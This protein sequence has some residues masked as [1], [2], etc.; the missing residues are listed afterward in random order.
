MIKQLIFITFLMMLLFFKNINFKE[1]KAI[2]EGGGSGGSGCS[3]LLGYDSVDSSKNLQWNG[4]SVYQIQLENAL[5]TWDNYGTVNIAYLHI[6][7]EVD[8][9]FYDVSESDSSY[10][11]WYRNLYDTITFNTYYMDT[12]TD[13]MIESIVLHEVGHALGLGHSYSGQIMY[14]V[15]QTIVNIQDMDGICY[16]TLWE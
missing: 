15:P 7:S 14:N 16:D 6:T 13:V 5:D 4:E 8:I 3:Y 9:T 11:A 1:V 12:A 2:Q 10:S